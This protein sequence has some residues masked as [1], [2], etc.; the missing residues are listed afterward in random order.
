MNQ[1]KMSENG[2][3]SLNLIQE[4]NQLSKEVVC[5]GREERPVTLTS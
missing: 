4:E 1:F 5:E 3:S 2:L